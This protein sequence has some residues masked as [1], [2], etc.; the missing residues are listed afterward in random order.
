[1]ASQHNECD[2]SNL[3]V[4]GMNDVKVGGLSIRKSAKKWGIKRTT[5]Q[6]RLSGRV[7]IN[8]CRGPPANL[9]KQEENQFT[10]WLIVMANRG[11]GVSKECEFYGGMCF[12]KRIQEV[13]CCFC[14]GQ[15]GEH[16]INI[17]LIKGRGFVLSLDVFFDVGHENIT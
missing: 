13:R 2:P 6:D 16:I 7:E 5:L 9:T 12:V 17:P 3:F 1:M 15:D 8:R 10:D 4:K 14:I 11:F